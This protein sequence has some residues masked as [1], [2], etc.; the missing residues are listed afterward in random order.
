MGNLYT[1][2]CITKGTK[3]NLYL[4]YQLYYI[5]YNIFFKFT[6]KESTESKIHRKENLNCTKKWK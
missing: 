1:C 5:I 4:I 6:S 3:R 2:V